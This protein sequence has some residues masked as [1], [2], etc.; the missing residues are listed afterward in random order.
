MNN[1]GVGSIFCLIAA[2]LLGFRYLTA[3]VYVSGA[4]S[5]GNELYSNALGYTGPVLLYTAIAAL[6]IGLCFLAVGIVKDGKNK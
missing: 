2:L 5:W 3:A 6:V 1:K 4:Q